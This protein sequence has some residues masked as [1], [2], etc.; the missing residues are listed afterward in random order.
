MSDT[1]EEL[2][3][4]ESE[5]ALQNMV[6]QGAFAQLKNS[7]TESVFLVGFAIALQAPN[8]VIGILAAIPF[9]TQLLQIPAVILISKFKSRRKLNILTQL[10]NRLGVLLMA[11]IPFLA[12]QEIGILVLIGA[13]AIQALFTSLGSPSWNS[14]LRDIVPQE[15]LGDFFATRMA[16]SGIMA[17]MASILGGLFIGEWIRLNPGEEAWGYSIIFLAAFIA[18]LLA[19][20]Y[21]RITP[22]P[23]IL[24]SHIQL[25]FKELVAEPFKNHNFRSLMYFSGVWSL[26]TAIVGPFLTVYIL[27]RLGFEFQIAA[28]LSALTQTVS[29]LFF[30]FWGRLSDRYSNKSILQVSAPLFIIAIFLW[31]FTSIAEYAQLTL[32]LLIIIHMLMGFSSAGVNLGT[33]NVGLKLAPRR[34]ASI[35]LAARGSIIAITSAIASI[36]GGLLADLFALHEIIFS[37]TWNY[38]GGVQI[39]DTY[40]ITGLDFIFLISVIIGIFALHRLALVKEEGE[41]DEHVIINAIV[42]ETRR[43]VKTLSTIDGLKHTFQVPLTKTREKI[44]RKRKKPKLELSDDTD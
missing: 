1:E 20:Y 27:S 3:A 5:V 10:G 13:I 4:E 6:K 22:E 41:V 42:A 9:I 11:L 35:Y 12:L 43:N 15:Q 26:S 28:I 38:P 44:P 23:P 14:W 7:L 16:V 19:I 8:V 30:R 34:E 37:I 25:K 2:T 39:I 32:P 31:T 33:N 18:G 40:S 29:V 24:S 17:I 36:I 21:T